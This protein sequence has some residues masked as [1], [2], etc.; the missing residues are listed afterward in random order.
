MT[1]IIT[2]QTDECA[3]ERDAVFEL[4]GIPAD[5]A[6]DEKIAAIYAR[7]CDL[8]AEVA[9]PAGILCAISPP[10]FEVIY[11]GAGR[12]EPH[13]PVGDIFKRA[14]KLALFVVTIGP[15]VSRETDERF[16]AH[17]F[18][19]GCMLDSAAS[20]AADRLAEVVERRFG[21]ELHASGQAA[22]DTGVMRYSPGYCGW[23]VSGQQKLFEYLHPKQ[24]GVTLGD[25]F[26]MQ[27]LKSVSGVII[28]GPKHIH[29]VG[30]AYPFCDQCET[31]DCRERWRALLAE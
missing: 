6:V 19:L 9:E 15:R 7:A 25:S 27:P 21:A 10:D 24:I 30:D 20:A 28:A 22:P 14:D 23:H 29:D 12:N 3:P 5:T 8:L 16:R 18:A 4:Q 26:L 17:D 1:E 2:F 31:H 13:T 11:Q